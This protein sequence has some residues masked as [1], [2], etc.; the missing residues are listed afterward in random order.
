MNTKPNKEKLLLL[1]SFIPHVAL[2]L[3]GVVCMFNRGGFLGEDLD[4]ASAF[5]MGIVLLFAEYIIVIVPLFLVSLAIHIGLIIRKINSRRHSTK[6]LNTKKLVITLSILVVFVSGLF[7]A[8]RIFD[9]ELR[10]MKRNIEVNFICLFA[11]EK[12]VTKNEQWNNIGMFNNGEVTCNTMMIDWNSKKVSMVTEYSVE[13]FKV[14]P[15]DMG[16]INSIKGNMEKVEEKS[17]IFND[18]S[19]VTVYCEYSS[20]VLLTVTKP[21]GS[22]LGRELHTG[23]YPEYYLHKNSFD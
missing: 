14:K 15:M 6:R 18:G 8:G 2:L 23:H 11:D 21:D 22:V 5:L 12:S 17:V 7:V 13:S 10:V 19:V 3:F 9:T 1:L 20:V 4:P 16:E